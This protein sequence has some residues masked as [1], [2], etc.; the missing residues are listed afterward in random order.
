MHKPSGGLH[1]Q[2]HRRSVH[3]V[4]YGLYH[5][6]ELVWLISV[7]VVGG[8][9]YQLHSGEKKSVYKPNHTTFL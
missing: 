3:R 9:I 7:H 1:M 2:T 4:T 5:S 6:V 8:V